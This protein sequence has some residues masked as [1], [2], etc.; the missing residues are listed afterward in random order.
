MSSSSNLFSHPNKPLEDHLLNVAN[1]SKL[2]FEDLN[3][4]NN[5]DFAKISFIIGISHDF[6]KATSFF[7]NLL[8]NEI[9][10]KKAYHSFLSAVFAYYNLKNFFNENDIGINNYENIPSL[11]YLLVIRHH[12]NLKSV[13]GNDAHTD[14]IDNLK[15]NFDELD[16]QIN[17]LKQQNNQ[18]FF[19]F[20]KSFNINVNDFLNRWHDLK[21]DIRKDLRKLTQSNDVSNYLILNILYSALLDADKL[22]ASNTSGVLRKNISDDIVDKYKG[23][24]FQNYKG[25]NKLREKSYL[26][27]IDMI[28]SLD[29]KNN[30]IFSLELPTGAGKTLTA[31]SASLKL[32]NRIKNEQ[33]FAPR[34]IYSL[35]F[36]SIIDQNE[37]I[38]REILDEFNLK[39]SDFLLKHNYMSDMNYES[40]DELEKYDENSSQL[41]TEGWYSEIIITTFIQLFYT[42]ISNKN[43]SLRK[44]HN[45]TNSIIILDEVQS[46]P[47]KFW[48]IVNKILTEISEKFNVWIILMTATQPLIFKENEE[49]IPLIE[50]K[51]EYFNSF[52]RV[53][54]NFDFK[55]RN[56][57]DFKEKSIEVICENSDKDMMFVL[58][59]INSSKELYNHIK[60]YFSDE[61]FEV[62]TNG[63]LTIEKSGKDTDLIYL[64]TNIIPKHRLNKINHIKESKNRKII[65]TTQL[66]EAGVDIS[67]DI[68]YRDMAPLDSIIQT[69]GRCNRDYSKELGEVNI[70]NLVNEKNISFGSFVYKNI[71]LQSTK[72]TISNIKSIDEKDFNQF[73]KKYY[74]ELL[75]YDTQDDSKK[76]LEI[77]NKLEYGK[78][79][80]NFQL[81]DNKTI[82][83]IDVFININYE[84]NKIWEEFCEI[85]KEKNLFKR[86]NMFLKI[87]SKFYSY[88]ISVNTKN[89]GRALLFNEWLGYIDKNY[90]D[91]YNME[92]GFIN[93]NDEETFIL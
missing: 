24:K 90:L 59:T 71:L 17:D 35:P 39:G 6:A 86:K 73:S 55:N 2:F 22:D 36:L 40:S 12:G 20:Y 63:I 29:I 38:I 37:S 5:F 19:E 1:L 30:K 13:R 11:G 26:E 54:F 14:E 84:S 49:I 27:V 3:F 44:F 60:E 74:E 66:I 75:K 85:K 52:N 53:K 46:I 18:I 42:L 9:K 32:R 79:Y 83:R 57:E 21:K 87:K 31:F 43:K 93:E 62:D 23:E 58:N 48:S 82:P 7:Q 47:Y 91:K 68:I 69:A 34:I 45:I 81:L 70:I 28:N 41:L 15:L 88:V 61:F 56:F 77:L 25:I 51:N 72:N 80:Q 65:V 33:G 64:S 78:I 67:V 76:L 16:V 50:N 89:F 4:K 10:T 8:F 92:T